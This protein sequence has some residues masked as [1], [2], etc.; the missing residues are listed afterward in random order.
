MGLEIER[1][2]QGLLFEAEAYRKSYKEGKAHSL[3][4]PK[5][6]IIQVNWGCYL[7]CNMCH[8][9]E[10]TQHGYNDQEALSLKE[11]RRVFT[12][13]SELGTHRITIVGTEPVMRPDFSQMLTSIHERGIKPEIYTAGIFLSQKVLQTILDTHTD[14][15][16]S[17]D[18]FKPETHNAIRR[19][20][21]KFNAYQ[22]TVE[23]IK[24][25]VEARSKAE[26]TSEELRLTINTTL[27]RSNIAELN[28]VTPSDIDQFGVDVFR[29]ALV[30]GYPDSDDFLLTS[31]DIETLAEFYQKTLSWKQEGLFKTAVDFA[32]SIYWVVNKEISPD[33]FNRN[34]LVPSG[35]ISG[36]EEVNCHIGE[37]SLVITPDG[38]VYPCLYLYDDNGDVITS[39]RGDFIMGNVRENDVEEVWNSEAFEEFRKSNYPDFDLR[40]C[41]TC[42]YTGHSFIIMDRVIRG[43]SEEPLKIGW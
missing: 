24:R 43:E 42:E 31:S 5:N 32:D 38:N 16:I 1:K 3:I 17:L 37:M 40:A 28:T 13:L 39:R 35:L 8:R 34:I 33:D 30:H 22:K 26:L 21:G 6:A 14:V 29:F 23:T 7:D 19:P 10:W 15:A 20:D 25:L 18:G 41:Q 2:N 12:Q 4:G 9:N 11:L 36:Q 27:Q